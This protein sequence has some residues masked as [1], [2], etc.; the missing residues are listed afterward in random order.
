MDRWRLHLHTGRETS[1]QENLN[2]AS[3]TIKTLLVED[4]SADARLTRELLAEVRGK[5]FDVDWANRLAV[6][7]QLLSREPYD[8]VLLD[9]EL[10]D[11]V[12]METLAAVQAAAPHVP[13]IVMTN[14]DDEELATGAVRQGAQDYLVKGTGDANLLSRAIFYAIERKRAEEE[15]ARSR[16][17]LQADRDRLSIIMDNSPQANLVLLDRDF[18][19]MM[20]N[21][22]YAESCRRPKEF[23]PGKN[24]FDLY[25]HAENEFIFRQV[26]DTGNSIEFKEKPFD[27]PDM[28]WRGTTYWDW[29]LTP[30]KD[31]S[32]QV[33]SLVFSLID[34]TQKVRA[35]KFSDTLNEINAIIGSTLDFDQ[36]IDIA[37]ATATR[38]MRA[39]ASLLA[40]GSPDDLVFRFSSGMDVKPGAR[41]DIA[42]APVAALAIS[43]GKVVALDE[44]VNEPELTDWSRN[45]GVTSGIAA[46][47]IARGNTIG[48]IS[49]RY[50]EHGIEFGQPHVDFVEKLASSFSLAIENSQLYRQE[51]ELRSHLQAY[52]TQLSV[53]HEIGLSLNRE[54]NRERLLNKVLRSAAEITMAGIGAM[55]LVEND[56]TE[57]VSMYYAPWFGD[58]CIIDSDPS[59]LHRRVE[60]LVAASGLDTIRINDFDSL[61]RPMDFPAGHPGIKG[62]LIGTIRD[63]MDRAK[64]YFMLS[65]KADDSQFTADDEEIIALLSAQASVA[66]ISA[67]NFEREHHVAETLQAALLPATPRREDIEIGLIYES[68]TTLARLGGDFYDFIE[69]DD[70]KLAV[71]IGDVSG[72]GLEAA[73]ATAMVK[74][75]LRAALDMKSGPAACLT[76]VNSVIARQIAMEK[77][78]TVGLLIVDVDD[79]SF[80]Y[81]SAGHPQPIFH[82]E[83]KTEP[84]EVSRSL[85]LGVLPQYDYTETKVAAPSGAA[86]VLYS[87]GLTEARPE[88]GEPYGEPRVIEKVKELAGLTAQDM[89]DRLMESAIEYSGGQLRDDIAVL[90]IR[91]A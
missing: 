14:C 20:V 90:V 28:P 47:L 17:E 64:G 79:H 66:M 4:S 50:L 73:T 75:S 72:K 54:M 83:D 70:R 22:A 52:A 26:R 55:L 71:V 21:S 34:V 82:A 63:T 45:T 60:K 53:L 5:V 84:V 25:P 58:R 74:Y 15:L 40:L 36:I 59:F 6:G 27:F 61:E 81:A 7:L 69:L 91:L 2:L 16:T 1:P 38:E 67:E 49:F 89:A 18:N 11:T 41:F 43:S 48:V 65:C 19:F 78:V 9:L 76:D 23:F 35:R 13:I 88:D 30:V 80:I 8:I 24:H 57:L 85:P 51:H 29:T 42:D 87:D 56:K 31:K 10:P 77:F 46:P 39:D 32:G 86:I 12:G 68:S 44:I 37:M 33:E 3:R 62:L